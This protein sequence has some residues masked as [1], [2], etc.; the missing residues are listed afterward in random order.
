MNKIY[1]TDKFITHFIQFH[2]VFS[3]R[4]CRK[5]FTDKKVKDRAEELIRLASEK[6][7]FRIRYLEIYPEH[8]RITVIVSPNQSPRF[9]MAKLKKETQILRKEFIQFANIR[10]FWTQSYLVSTKQSFPH[11]EAVEFVA[12]KPKRFGNIT[13]KPETGIKE[14]INEKIK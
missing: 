8:I 11:K 1:T 5:V 7:S 4:M 9:I 13:D 12:S 2:F 3:T 6:Y 10:N 14:Y